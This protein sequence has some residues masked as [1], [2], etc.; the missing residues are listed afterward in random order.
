MRR[1]ALALLAFAFCGAASAYYWDFEPPTYTGSAAGTIATGQDGWYNPVAG[2]TDGSIFTYA[3]NTLGFPGN[4]YGGQQFLGGTAA[5]GSAYVRAQHDLS[6][7]GFNEWVMTY[8]F[9]VRYNGQLPSTDNV[10]SVSLQP[11]ATANIFQSLFQWTDFNTAAAF[12][13]R[14][15]IFP[16]AG[17]TA[18]TVVSAGAAWENLPLNHWFRSKSKWNFATGRVLEVSIQDL[19]A[20]GSPTVANPTDWY[21]SGGANNTLGLALPTGVR[22]FI[23]GT[24][25]GNTM[26][27]DNL[28]IVPEPATLLVLGAG[29]AYAA[30]RRR[31]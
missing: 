12:H 10:G 17:G 24:T 25:A 27:F 23:G 13:A 20:G 6:F 8:D 16:A 28:E 11:S 29:L 4:P 15:G 21:L 18:I 31:R 3:G 30:L 26:G 1:M 5:G 2:S 7:A 22:F 9:V 19:T 14:Y